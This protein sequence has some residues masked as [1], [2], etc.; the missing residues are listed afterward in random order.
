MTDT[1]RGGYKKALLDMRD[2]IFDDRSYLNNRAA[3]SKKQYRAML[4]SLLNLLLTD[5]CT[6]DKWMEG[7]LEM[8]YNEKEN[9]FLP[10]GRRFN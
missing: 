7:L 5:P 9:S 3:K 10:M 4:V 6:L 2:F 8:K 1:Y